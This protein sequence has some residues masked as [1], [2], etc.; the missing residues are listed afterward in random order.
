MAEIVGFPEAFAAALAEVAP[1]LDERARRLLLGAGARQLGRGGIKLIAAATGAAADTVGKGAA[2]LEAGIVAE[3]RVRAPGAGR[4]PV[5]YHDPGL[6]PALDAL[7]DPETRGDPMSRLRWT[8]KSTVKLADEL[9]AQG[10]RVGPD[11]VARLFKDHDYSL[12]GNAKTIEGRQHP[13]RDAQFRYL[14]A[15][16]TA[17]LVAG[18]PVIS[19]D[20]KKKENVGAYKNGGREYQPK[21]QPVATNTYDFL[22]EGGK[23]VPYGVYDVGANTGWVNV[24][25]DADTGAFAVE[26]IRRWWT[27]IGRLAYPGVTRLLITADGG[28]SNGSRLR[29]WKTQL[30]ELA[31]ETGLEITVCHL[32]PGTSKWNKIEHRMF[33]AITMNW[34]GRPLE[35]HEVVVETIA[36][37]TTK[38]GLTIQAAL[39]T[40]SYP[41]GIT[42]TNKEMQTFEAAHLQRHTFHGDWNYT[43][44]ASPTNGTTRPNQQK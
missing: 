43:V 12:Q 34:R 35:T 8:T 25:T 19:V 23:A 7:V 28:G 41:R 44:T 5:E 14:N 38:T 2:E 11:T 27:T 6:W 1:V 30:A 4:K 22:G 3:G 16:V 36:A 42:I 37:T 32:P 24:G 18:L 17:F 15:Q 10:H 39:D 9:T 20:T 40:N 29:L 13:D 31:T 33:S 26:S 21:G